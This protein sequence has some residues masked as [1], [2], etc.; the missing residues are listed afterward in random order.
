M[1]KHDEETVYHLLLHCDAARD[2]WSVKVIL[3][4]YG[5]DSRVLFSLSVKDAL[6]LYACGGEPKQLKGGRKLGI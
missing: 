2:L 1:C 5:L 6:L 4:L 3:F